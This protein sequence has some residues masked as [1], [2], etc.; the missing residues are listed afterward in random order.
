MLAT[1]SR[2]RMA[3]FM[4]GWNADDRA[5]PSLRHRW[6][7]Q[8]VPRGVGGKHDPDLIQKYST[9]WTEENK[10]FAEKER[11]YREARPAIIGKINDSLRRDLLQIL[12]MEC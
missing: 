1:L 8:H 9:Q 4:A 2:E 6:M 3:E 11:L 7:T 10:N 5:Q 12:L